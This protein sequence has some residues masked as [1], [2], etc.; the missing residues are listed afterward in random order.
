MIHQLVLRAGHLGTTNRYQLPH[1][2]LLR[3]K[4]LHGVKHRLILG[5]YLGRPVVHGERRP[6]HLMALLQPHTPLGLNNHN[7]LHLN[8]MYPSIRILDNKLHTP[9]GLSNHNNLHLKQMY[10]SIQL[11]DS[12]SPEDGLV[13][14]TGTKGYVLVDQ[15]R[16]LIPPCDDP[17]LKV[18]QIDDPT[19]K[20]LQIANHCCSGPPPG[21]VVTSSIRIMQIPSTLRTWRG[22]RSIGVQILMPGLALLPISR[23]WEK[24]GQMCKVCLLCS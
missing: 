13:Q 7:N 1:G 18:L 6:H 22:V 9:L 24:Q 19:H 20:V 16:K 14:G 5:V 4:H 8:Q 17:T 11:L 23:E 3:L 12:P 15:R 10:P 21:L 2:G